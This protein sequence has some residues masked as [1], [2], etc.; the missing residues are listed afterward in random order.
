MMSVKT[1][2]VGE[3]RLAQKIRLAG[4]IAGRSGLVGCDRECLNFLVR[5]FPN[6]HKIC[7]NC[8]NEQIICAF[9]FYIMKT[10]DTRLQIENYSVFK[11]YGLTDKVYLTI[12]TRLCNYYQ[13]N[14]PLKKG[15]TNY[16]DKI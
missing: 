6:F 13:K 7:A 15:K 2:P 12:I 8:S 4:V 10:R 11:E 1:T 3:W 5:N 16:Y 9:A 14:Q